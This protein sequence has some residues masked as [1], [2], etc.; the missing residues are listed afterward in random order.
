MAE[1]DAYYPVIYSLYALKD[2]VVLA[3]KAVSNEAMLYDGYHEQSH[4]Q[5]H[6]QH[7]GDGIGERLDEIVDYVVSG[8]EEGEEYYADG[9]RSRDDA[10]GKLACRG[11]GCLPAGHT[12]VK[13]VNVAID[14][15]D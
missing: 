3:A 7:Y 1:T 11:D 9:E 6:R 8:K 10:G 2:Q 12:L 5:R 4:E 14:H 15:H 13:T